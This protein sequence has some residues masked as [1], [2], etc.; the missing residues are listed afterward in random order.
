MS[1][2]LV[3]RSKFNWGGQG[4]QTKGIRQKNSPKIENPFLLFPVRS[5]SKVS[6]ASQVSFGSDSSFGLFQLVLL[7][8]S[9][10]RKNNEC[11]PKPNFWSLFQLL[12]HFLFEKAEATK[13]LIAEF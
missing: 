4:I 2:L 6:G 13:R 12:N 3:S 9:N 1:S 8:N 11:L 7:H 10:Q 5:K